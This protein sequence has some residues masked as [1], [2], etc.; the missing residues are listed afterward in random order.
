MTDELD[1]ISGDKPWY[2]DGL[3]FKCTQCGHCCR[4]PGNVWVSDNEIEEL[5]ALVELS[6]EQFRETYI[7]R[8]ARRGL[9]IAQKRNK[10][11]IFWD[12]TGGCQVYSA[13]PKQCRTYP[14]W[15]A[16]V[17]TQRDWVSE[18][19]DCPGVGEGPTHTREAIEAHL[20]DDGIPAHRNRARKG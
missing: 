15:N 14:F 13:R 7:K 12:E 1:R 10:D 6:D 3:Q 2:K 18:R 9:L 17:Q 11:C 5:A 20:A 4:G 8:A 19:R 16:I